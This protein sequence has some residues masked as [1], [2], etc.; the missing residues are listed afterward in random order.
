MSTKTKRTTVAETIRET[1]IHSMKK[2]KNIILF[3]E[4]IDDGAAMFKT[5]KGLTKIFGP[6]RV[7]EMPLSENLF[8]GAA[9]GASML[10]DKVIINLQRVFQLLKLC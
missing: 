9:I 1:L 4:G 3:G 10:G 5:T 6:K 8:V 7:F 2:D